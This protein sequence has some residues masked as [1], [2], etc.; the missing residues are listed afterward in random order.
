[1]TYLSYYFSDNKKHLYRDNISEEEYS[2]IQSSLKVLK[3]SMNEID[4]FLMLRENVL[5]FLKDAES[6]GVAIDNN[7]VRLN[8]HIMNWLNSFYAWVEYHE[9][10][11]NDTFSTLKTKYYDDYFEYRFAYELRIYTTHKNLCI[12]SITFDVLNEKTIFKIK[13]DDILE[14][15]KK[16]KSTVRHELIAMREETEYIDAVDFVKKFFNVISHFQDKLW[17][18]LMPN[19]KSNFQYIQSFVPHT[20]GITPD[21]Y[22]ISSDEQTYCSIGTSLNAYLDKWSKISISEEMLQYIRSDKVGDSYD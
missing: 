18:S 21:S 20:Q 8:R 13:L 2:K 22:V 5:D 9:R 15:H 10:C 17:K 1:M 16:I 3:E 19:I 14:N 6:N 11:C 7:F 4:Y 12:T